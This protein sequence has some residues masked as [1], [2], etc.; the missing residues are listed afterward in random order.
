MYTRIHKNRRSLLLIIAFVL[1]LTVVLSACGSN[2]TV[3][4]GSPT[5]TSTPAPTATKGQADANGCPAG[6]AVASRP[7]PA[8][9]TLTNKDSGNTINVT[10]GQSIE[11]DLPFGHTWAG[12]ADLG[13]DLL[14]LQSPAGYDSPVAR[15]CVWR[16]IA[17][18]TGTAHFSFVGRPLCKKGQLCPMYVL[19]VPFTIDIK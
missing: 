16:F 3:G 7:A 13:S 9:V 12:P 5:V 14:A 11:V 4:S 10:R 6:A 1:M 17:T 8:N 19:A 15:A 18:G 2:A